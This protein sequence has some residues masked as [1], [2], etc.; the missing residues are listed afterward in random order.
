M[1]TLVIS[2]DP[3]GVDP[4]GGHAKDYKNCS[5]YLA[6]RIRLGRESAGHSSLPFGWDNQWDCNWNFM[7]EEFFLWMVPSL[8][9]WRK[10]K[11]KQTNCCFQLQPDT[12]HCFLRT[13]T[14][15]S[16]LPCRQTPQHKRWRNINRQGERG[17]GA[18]KGFRQLVYQAINKHVLCQHGPCSLRL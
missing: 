15:W 18:T 16:N 12:S 17:K 2:T 11:T 5:S 1:V 9:K 6:L 14:G 7:T 4:P 10:K 13:N 8:R 3:A